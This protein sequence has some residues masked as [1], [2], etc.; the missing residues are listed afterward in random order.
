MKTNLLIFTLF[1]FCSKNIPSNKI[2]ISTEH[3]KCEFPKYEVKTFEESIKRQKEVLEILKNE[4]Q[5]LR[6]TIEQI[7]N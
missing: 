5:C 7:N 1:A 4:T 3:C 2:S 6:K